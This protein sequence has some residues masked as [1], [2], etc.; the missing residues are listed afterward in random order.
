MDD[1]RRHVFSGAV[2]E[3]LSGFSRAVVVGDQVFLSGTIGVDPECGTLAI[4]SEAQAE[5]ALNTI[6]AA[7]KDAGSGLQDVVRV[8]TFV[9]DDA[10]LGAVAKVLKR[11]LGKYYPAQT[12]TYARNTFEGALVEIEV[13]AICCSGTC[14]A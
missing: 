11:R 10:D 1:T 7:L 4:G 6:E 3:E 5:H 9:H 13:D 12:T 14:L 2:I 8:R